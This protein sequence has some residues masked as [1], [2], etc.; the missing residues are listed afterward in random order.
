MLASFYTWLR[1]PLVS[2]VLATLF[3]LVVVLLVGRWLRNV[4]INRIEGSEARYRTRKGFNV[5]MWTVRYVVPFTRRR[6]TKDE[7]CER[8]LDAVDGT[9]GAVSLASATF[10]VVQA[11]TIDV[12]LVGE[13]RATTEGRRG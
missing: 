9:Q 4:L 7:L 3:A 10:H 6:T 13:A 11:P 12:R 8:I 5:A 1:E 2:K